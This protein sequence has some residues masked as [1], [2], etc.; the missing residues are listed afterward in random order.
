MN[1]WPYSAVIHSSSIL[2]KIVI[3]EG[4]DRFCAIYIF[5]ALFIYFVQFV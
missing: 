5:C 3:G 4:I 1:G 2:R